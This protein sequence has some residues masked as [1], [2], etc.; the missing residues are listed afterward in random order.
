MQELE[1]E[2][3]ELEALFKQQKQA[4]DKT[5]KLAD[6]MKDEQI[7]K[8]LLALRAAKKKIE[9]LSYAMEDSIAEDKEE[10]KD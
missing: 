4:H 5:I 9:K 7:K 10:M 8:T 3:A 6:L 2:V 1:V